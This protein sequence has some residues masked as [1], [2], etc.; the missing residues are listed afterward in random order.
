MYH[1]DFFAF[2]GKARDTTILRQLHKDRF[3]FFWLHHTLNSFISL[4]GVW[5]AI[6]IV[7]HVL[8]MM[9]LEETAI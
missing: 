3:E 9:E 4:S 8:S 5:C 7:S 2:D 1:L 6:L